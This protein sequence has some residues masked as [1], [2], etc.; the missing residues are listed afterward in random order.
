MT[1]TF[2]DVFFLLDVFTFEGVFPELE[3]LFEGPKNGSDVIFLEVSDDI[4]FFFLFCV[5]LILFLTG[6]VIPGIEYSVPIFT[7]CAKSIPVFLL[8]CKVV[9]S[10]LDSIFEE[11]KNGAGISV[12]VSVD[13]L[14]PDCCVILDKFC[15]ER[16]FSLLSN[17][18]PV[19]KE[20]FPVFF[21]FVI[22]CPIFGKVG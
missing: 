2:T 12:E 19:F 18:F 6:P 15:V 8:L 21:D 5:V 10:G 22:L 7:L 16:S 1:F 3:F 14:I 13:S 9:L 20:L 17:L 11:P 4:L